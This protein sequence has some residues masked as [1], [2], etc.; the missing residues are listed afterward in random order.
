MLKRFIDHLYVRSL[1]FSLSLSLDDFKRLPTVTPT[2]CFY[3]P[4][5]PR[6]YSVAGT[7]KD[8]RKNY[9]DAIVACGQMVHKATLASI[10]SSAEESESRLS[11]CF[12]AKPNVH[13]TQ[14][15][16]VNNVTQSIYHRVTKRGVLGSDPGD[17][18][19]GFLLTW[20]GITLL[21]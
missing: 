14:C 2:R 4:T 7:T 1:S 3:C 6:C 20:V 5:V 15:L 13:V 19:I 17:C 12:F 18:G 8:Q 10:H 21:T 9:D 16:R 11:S